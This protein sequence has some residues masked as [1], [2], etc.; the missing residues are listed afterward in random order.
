MRHQR[1]IGQGVAG[2]D[3]V[4]GVDVQVAI[5]RDVVLFLHAAFAADGDRHL[6]LAFV[7]SQLDATA[8]LGHGGGVLGLA[9]LEDLG[10]ARQT[11]GDVL[12]AAGGPGL[13]GEQLAGL[14]FLAF[15]HLDSGPG[16]Q[17]VDVQNLA[18]GVLDDDLRVLVALVLDH[19]RPFDDLG[20]RVLVLGLA[21][22]WSCSSSVWTV[23]PSMISTNRMTPG[24]LRQDRRSVRVP[25]EQDRAGLDG[26]AVLARGGCR[27]TGP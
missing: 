25:L 10:H 5:A 15:D 19:D 11:A 23:S 24:D 8:D 9:G 13:M 14:H 21:V 6:A 3:H 2:L 1:T 27:R 17:I 7:A 26:L 20:V 22:S 4:A 12:R 16:G 18:L